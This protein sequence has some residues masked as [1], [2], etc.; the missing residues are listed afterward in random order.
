MSEDDRNILERRGRIELSKYWPDGS[1]FRRVFPTK[2]Q[3]RKMRS[4]IET[5]IN[6]GAWL[7]LKDELSR[8]QPK[9][10]LAL[11][12]FS[13]IFLEH[14]RKKNRRCDFHEE[15]IDRFL[16]VV[17]SIRLKQF[18]RADAV[19]L[20]QWRA[21]SVAGSTVNRMM[22][23]L[24][25][26]LSHALHLGHIDTHPMVRFPS[27]PEEAR[28][29]RVMTIDEERG[30]IAALLKIDSI[31]GAFA[32]VMGETGLRCSEAERLEWRHVDLSERILAVDRSKGKRPRYVPISDFAKDLFGT[33]P[34]VADDP[35]CFIRLET[36]KPVADVRAPFDK[37]R[38]VTGMGWV[39]PEDFRHFRA[40][41][42]VRLGVD[43][44]T[45]Q[46]LLGHADIH[47]TMRYAHFAPKH[48]ARSIVEA[49]RDEAQSLR[50]LLIDFR[51]DQ[52]RTE[53]V[54]EL[55]RLY[56]LAHGKS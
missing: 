30:F 25:S 20:Q 38:M 47:T 50:Q 5:A 33:L 36:F 18:T 41:Q 40:T 26:M 55:E 23:V 24:S 9:E 46:Q 14:C 1:R 52:N 2:V 6:S 49:Q 32:G 15:E 56:T 16:P 34:R 17:G 22:D 29:L 12:E 28:A 13:V 10:D 43:L 21:Q 53:E 19:R 42:W 48:A 37:A 51:Q 35:H 39:N 27:Y 44:K 4:Q 3:A 54:G 8:S 7:Q 45:V 11:K 31:V